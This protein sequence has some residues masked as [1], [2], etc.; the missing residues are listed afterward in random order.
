MSVTD[1]PAVK[2]YKP[3]V[4]HHIQRLSEARQG[5]DIDSPIVESDCAELLEAI[6]SIRAQS[7]EHDK[8]DS[9]QLHNAALETVF[10]EIFVHIVATVAISEPAFSQVW[11]LLDI[12]TVLSDNDLCEPG[13]GFWLIEELLDS[14]T[15]DGCRKVFDY[16]DSRRERITA[17]NFKHKSLVILRCCNELLRRLSRAEDTVFCGR[18]FIFL[19]QSFPLGDKSSVNLRG[20]FHVE[21]VTTFDPAPRKSEDAIKP[22]ELDM[23]ARTPQATTS[24]ARTP[25]SSSQIQEQDSTGRG[26]PVAG[27]AIKSE[28][29]DQT[30]PPPD[31][32]TLYPKFWSLQTL[33]SSPTKLFEPSNMAM[34]KEGLALTLLC[35]KSVSHGS[36]PSTAPSDVRRGLKRKH[37]DIESDSNASLPAS[38]FNP[39]YL[40][41]RDLFDLEIHDIDFRRHILVQALIMIDFLLS[42]TPAAKA[43]F[44]GLTNKSVLYPFTLSEE[45][46]KWAQSTRA[47]IASYLQQGNGNEGKFY[48]R[49]VDTVLSRDKNWVRW[50]AE[51]CPSISRDPVPPHA[52]LEAKDTLT[53]LTDAHKAPVPNPPGAGDLIF[54]SKVEPLEAL[55]RP[56]TRHKLPTV[57]EYYRGIETDD[58]D[59]DFAVTEDEKREIEERKA[60]KLW[61]AL[62]ASDRRFALCERVQYGGNLK[63][64]VEEGP[65][66]DVEEK[67]GADKEAR[68]NENGGEGAEA[69][70]AEAETDEKPDIEIEDQPQVK[71]EEQEQPST[72]AATAQGEDAE[73]T[74]VATTEAGAQTDEK[75]GVKVE[76]D[77]DN[78]PD[79][80][81]GEAEE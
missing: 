7:L 72:T 32:D 68:E 66:Q 21:N 43:K 74:D 54:L 5:S 53:K 28:V 18:V 77:E 15:I 29:K 63:A 1:V 59:M 64:L 9:P 73:M 8:A 42:M 75:S 25:A 65:N 56:S 41:N 48:Y 20:E 30:Q 24:G 17:K 61:R 12:I 4:S 71:K 60:G 52:Y 69:V 79:R 45:D 47:A 58:L 76:N 33:F 44:E 67:S 51:N 6:R 2:A 40:T 10:R 22:M 3:L 14:Q 35:F 46:T 34:L 50:K 19:F 16:L 36:A 38:T 26:T 37:S 27:K 78:D 13:L 39:K 62:R 23:D 55:K 80:D 11:V 57:E 81:P 31:L 70:K 49:M